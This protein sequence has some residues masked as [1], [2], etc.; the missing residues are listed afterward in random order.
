MGAE[1]RFGR[2]KVV[3][4]EIKKGLKQL[5]NHEYST[6]ETEQD[7]YRG[8]FGSTQVISQRKEYKGKSKSVIDKNFEKFQNDNIDQIEKYQIDYSVIGQLGFVARKVKVE[9]Y[10]KGLKGPFIIKNG[11]ACKEYKNVTEIKNALK[12]V[13]TAKELYGNEVYLA[14]GLSGPVGR[15]TAEQRIYKT[16]PKKLP[17]KYQYIDEFVEIAYGGFVPV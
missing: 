4:K 13:S 5:I 10:G 9:L 11:F 15:I 7:S 17:K 14:N 3:R 6:R 2:M 16:E 12:N 8:D 1:S